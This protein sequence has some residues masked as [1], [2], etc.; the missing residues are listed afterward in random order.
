ME[1]LDIDLAEQEEA[2]VQQGGVW[3]SLWRSYDESENMT[4]ESS[5]TGNARAILRRFGF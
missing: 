4:L 1:D 2:A 5:V 3:V